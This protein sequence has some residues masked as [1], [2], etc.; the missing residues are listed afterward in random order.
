MF[1]PSRTLLEPERCLPCLLYS[2]FNIFHL[3]SP[4][5]GHCRH[6]EP[7][8]SPR[9][10]FKFSKV[11]FLVYFVVNLLL[12]L[13]TL[14]YFFYYPD[15]CRTEKAQCLMFVTDHLFCIT[16]LLLTFI[17]FSKLKTYIDEQNLWVFIFE[18][19]HLHSL[20]KSTSRETHRCL[21]FRQNLDCFCFTS[22]VVVMAVLHGYFS[23]E[24][25]PFHYWRR[26]AVVQCYLV[27]AFGLFDHLQKIRFIGIVVESL[28]K[29]LQ[30]AFKERLGSEKKC[31]VFLKKCFFFVDLVD[32][33]M[34]RFVT[35]M[36]PVFFTWLL[37]TIAALILNIYILLEYY[38]YGSSALLIVQIRTGLMIAVIVLLMCEAETKLKNKV[39]T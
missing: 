28:E 39:S 2:K 9:T 31:D 37:T 25:Y 22:T 12:V 26:I 18:N 14:S 38:E 27:Q 6:L 34:K 15:L 35:N 36:A 1:S 4:V 30:Q 10:H 16:A 32:K 29:S 13:P 5:Q 17:F 3:T 21:R 20:D 7:K 33:N 8:T 24:E 19:K 11:W 23:Y